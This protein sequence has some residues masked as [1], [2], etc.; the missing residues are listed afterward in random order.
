VNRNL[1]ELIELSKIDKEID[2]YNPKIEAIDK[3][4]LKSQQK[5][6]LLQDEIDSINASIEDNHKKNKNV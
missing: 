3:K 5:L 2:G 4:L 6:D 1:Q